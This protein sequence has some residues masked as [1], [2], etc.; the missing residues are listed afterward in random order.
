MEPSLRRVL[1]FIVEVILLM[2]LFSRCLNYEP[3]P[4][5]P[6]LALFELEQ[7]LYI[8]WLYFLYV[9][10]SVA[11]ILIVTTIVFLME[12]FRYGAWAVPVRPLV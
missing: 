11:T 3:A 5:P 1:A 8:F 6:L 12:E 7:S 9:A 2:Y 4:A 10:E